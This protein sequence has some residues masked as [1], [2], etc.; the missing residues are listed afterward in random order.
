MKIIQNNDRWC[1]Y[2]TGSRWYYPETQVPFVYL[3][4]PANRKPYAT[5]TRVERCPFQ[6]QLS[7]VGRIRN[8]GACV[9][10]IYGICT[11]DQCL[12]LEIQYRLYKSIYEKYV[13]LDVF[14]NWF[15]TQNISKRVANMKVNRT[16][17]PEPTSI[18]NITNHDP[19]HSPDIFGMVEAQEDE[20][21]E[22]AG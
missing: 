17:N 6:E 20:N 11:P 9:G 5:I 15:I 21:T 14:S 2:T 1:L 13:C 18:L 7:I 22:T 19:L 3:N 8:L 16:Y 4:F 12:G 10:E